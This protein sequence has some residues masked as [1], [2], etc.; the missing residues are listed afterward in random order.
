VCLFRLSGY[1]GAK[2]PSDNQSAKWHPTILSLFVHT[3][4]PQ[5]FNTGRS[6]TLAMV[7]SMN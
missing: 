5:K 7:A 2:Q 1:F 4:A 3:H 6:K